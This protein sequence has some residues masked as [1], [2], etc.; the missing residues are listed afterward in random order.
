MKDNMV[1]IDINYLN[2]LEQM[3][4][5]VV[6]VRESDVEDDSESDNSSDNRVEI[7]GVYL[8]AKSRE[9]TRTSS[10]VHFKGERDKGIV[11][12]EMNENSRA[13]N[14]SNET[15]ISQSYHDK[16]KGKMMQAPESSK[17]GLCLSSVLKAFDEAWHKSP[18]GN[19]MEGKTE[20]TIKSFALEIAASLDKGNAIVVGGSSQTVAFSPRNEANNEV[21]HKAEASQ[22]L[23]EGYMLTRK[24]D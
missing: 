19:L 11:I 10:G 16:G 5:D 21:L 18:M 4:F 24:Q 3:T 2:E 22:D 1:L 7:I 15:S 9:I 13:V 23:A 17:Q 6:I 12:K 20:G 8:P 14:R